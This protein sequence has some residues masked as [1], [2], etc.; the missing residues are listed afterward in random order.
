MTHACIN[1]TSSKP[2][3]QRFKSSWH[4]IANGKVAAKL[5]RNEGGWLSWINRADSNGW[6]CVDFL[7]LAHAKACIM[8]WW[9]T[10]TTDRA[11]DKYARPHIPEI[12]PY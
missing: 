1:T 12:E 11:F 3:W 7:T 2:R 8:Q 10:R 4:L 9:A 5:V 6:S